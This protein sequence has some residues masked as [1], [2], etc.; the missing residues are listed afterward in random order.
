MEFFSTVIMVWVIIA[1]FGFVAGGLVGCFVL[2]KRWLEGYIEHRWFGRNFDLTAFYIVLFI[3]VLVGFVF[4]ECFLALVK[5]AYSADETIGSYVVKSPLMLAALLGF[6]ILIKRV[7]ETRLQSRTMQYNAANELLWSKDNSSRIAGINALWRLAN[8]YPKEEYHHVMDVFTQFIKNPMPYEWEK[9]TKEQD[10][11]AGKRDDIGKILRYMGAEKVVGADSYEINLIAVHLEGAN[12][13]LL[14]FYGARL[15]YARLEGAFFWEAHLEGAD[16]WLAHLEG[17][18]LREAHLEGANLRETHLEGANLRETHLEG[19]DLNKARLE[20]ARLR[21]VYLEGANLEG[22]NLDR[23]NLTLAIINGANF[24]NAK[25]LT[26]TQI[27]SCVFISDNTKF[28]DPPKL[29]EGMEHTYQ[30][31]TLV[32]WFETMVQEYPP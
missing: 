24:T 7:A 2:A 13:G 10:K 28:K 31:M 3:F 29:P 4:D 8:D 23:A 18:N 27:D 11:K 9:G 22:A 30:I 15:L 1:I 17:A 19:A 5:S 14:R 21:W 16:L 25:N 20:G 12:L 26:Q 6:P 32:E